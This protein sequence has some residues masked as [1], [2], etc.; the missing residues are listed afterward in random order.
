MQLR[1]VA[2]AAFACAVLACSANTQFSISRAP[3]FSS[4]HPH[5]SVFAVL[6]DGRPSASAWSEIGPRL[7][8]TFP[9][10]VGSCDAGFGE[11]MRSANRTLFETVE[12]EARTDGISDESISRAAE[13]SKA[14]FVLVFEVWGAVGPRKQQTPSSSNAPAMMGGGRGRRAGA[15]RWGGHSSEEQT[16]ALEVAARVYAPKTHE[17]VAALE[18]R[19][20]GSSAEEALARFDGELAQLLPGAACTG[21]TW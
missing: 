13:S 12:S 1:P 14:D 11:R 9:L 18:M 2:L 20:S 3:G 16:D 15:G 21:W 17:W 5:V 19:Y 4:E 6:R 10:G 8:T 7:S